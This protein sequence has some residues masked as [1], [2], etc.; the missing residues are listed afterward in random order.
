[1]LKFF[2]VQCSRKPA[3][4]FADRLWNSTKGAGTDDA[5]LIRIVVSRSE[6]S[7]LFISL[8]MVQ[9][10]FLRLTSPGMWLRN[11][12][13]KVFKVWVSNNSTN[14][15]R[16]FVVSVVINRGTQRLLTQRTTKNIW[17]TV[18]FFKDIRS[19]SSKFLRFSEVS[20]FI[21]EIL[22][23]LSKTVFWKFWYRGETSPRIF[24]WKYCH[25]DPCPW[26][27]KWSH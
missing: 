16:S 19:I 13:Q 14:V 24:Y 6:V 10:D 2:A 8:L 17:I 23:L 4:Y 11:P 21:T 18:P 1:M 15:L 5:T 3:E 20:H 26:T 9:S 25:S 22:R 7:F 12:L 27:V